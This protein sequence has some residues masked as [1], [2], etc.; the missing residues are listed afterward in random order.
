L[1]ISE[2]GG[3]RRQ[4]ERVGNLKDTGSKIQEIC[5]ATGLAISNDKVRYL[6]GTALIVGA[7]AGIGARC[8]Q[9]FQARGDNI[10]LVDGSDDV[11][12]PADVVHCTGQ[13][14]D[15]ALPSR[16]VAMAMERFGGL[17]SVVVTRSAMHALP[18][19]QWT[20]ELWDESCAI[21]LR[22]PF[23]CAQAAAPA[24]IR[25][26]NPSLTFLS[27]TAARRGQ[28][29]SHAYQA[30]KAG[31]DGLV[32]SLTAELGPHGV[33]V[34]TVLAGWIDTP[35]NNQ[36]WQAQA[37]PEAARAAFDR[38][39]PLQRHGTADEVVKTILFLAS[40]DGAYISGTS[41][42]VDGGITAV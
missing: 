42:V 32:R 21:N 18:L 6:M 40:P 17:D 3:A 2:Q 37:D 7:A 5:P 12:V 15:P 10:V 9:A 38:R 34:N 24:L 33:R 28:P 23:L 29:H 22:L 36:Y 8:V 13:P 39:I 14:S 27:S 16:A 25:S 11:V 20:P 19:D 4:L 30:T 26:N 31:L 35:F 41:L 1:L